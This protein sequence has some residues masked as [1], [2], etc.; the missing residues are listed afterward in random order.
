MKIKKIFACICG[1][2]LACTFN[3]CSDD[4]QRTIPEIPQKI[5]FTFIP[6]DITV[7]TFDFDL[8]VSNQDAPYICLYVPR[9]LI[10]RVP[11]HEL[12]DFLMEDLRKQAE[13]A[14]KPFAQYLAEISYRGDKEFH[15]DGLMRGTLYELVAFAV[16]KE[17]KS[18]RTGHRT[19]TM[20][21]FYIGCK[22]SDA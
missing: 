6:Y 5:D 10:D 17:W 8:K 7:S 13:T 14:N 3:A 4:E 22:E 19:C 18:E 9:T 21:F 12:P 11:K 2:A 16:H 1:I 15:L 20:D